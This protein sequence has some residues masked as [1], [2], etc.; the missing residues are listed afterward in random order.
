MPF[1]ENNHLNGMK[2]IRHQ[3]LR[4]LGSWLK[5]QESSNID[6]ALFTEYIL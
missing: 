4:D 5:Y 6:P 2:F 1:S 3:K